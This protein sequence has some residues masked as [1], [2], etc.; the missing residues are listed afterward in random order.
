MLKLL[1]A[2]LA[3]FVLPTA[4]QAQASAPPPTEPVEVM[5]LGTYHMGNP[6]QDLHNARVD[7]VTTPEKQAQLEAVAQALARF[8]PTAVAIERVARDPAAPLDH[9]YPEFTPA[10]LLTN[11]DERVQVGYRLA[12]RLGLTRV[13]AVDEPDR[14]GQPSYF[15]FEDVQAWVQAAGRMDELAAM[16]QGVAAFIAEMER[17]QATDSVGR[18][19]A[20]MNDPARIASDQGFY[21][22][23]M[24][25]GAGDA[26]PGAVLNGRWYTRNAVIFARIMQVAEPGDRIVVVYGAGHAFWLRQMVQTTPGFVLVE[27]NDYLPR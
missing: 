26:Q 3:A 20:W 23:L 4:V 18:V 10:D 2:A 16:H 22:R 27:P 1:A 13:Y 6:G 7:P 5:I 9:R 8:R 25:F 17:R 15:P 14:E 12:R 24:A 11:P 19:L 21:A